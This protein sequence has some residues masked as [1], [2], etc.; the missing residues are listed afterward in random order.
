MRAGSGGRVR[1]RWTERKRVANRQHEAKEQ[2]WMWVVAGDLDGLWRRRDPGP[3]TL[4][5]EDR[6]P[7]LWRTD[8]TLAFDPLR[9]HHPVAGVALLWIKSSPF[10]LFHAFAICTANSSGWA[11]PRSTSC[12][13]SFNRSLL[14]ARRSVLRGIDNSA[15]SSRQ[16]KGP[17]DARPPAD[18]LAGARLKAALLTWNRSPRR[19]KA[20]LSPGKIQSPALN[21]KSRPLR[22]RWPQIR[23]SCLRSGGLGN[24]LVTL[25]IHRKSDR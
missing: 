23:A 18:S 4:A 8:A 5:L 10:T 19:S 16:N 14:V 3:R 11:R 7:R 2:N 24:W 15:R 20:G 9:H 21:Q 12:A 22:N 25:R 13:S 17:D 6:E 1:E